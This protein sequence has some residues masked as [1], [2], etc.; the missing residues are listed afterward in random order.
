MRVLMPVL[1]LAT[2]ILIMVAAPSASIAD[3]PSPSY[4]Y[5]DL[6][7]DDLIFVLDTEDTS[8]EIWVPYFYDEASSDPR[9]IR[10]TGTMMIRN[11]IY[12]NRATTATLHFELQQS[13]LMHRVLVLSNNQGFGVPHTFPEETGMTTVWDGH[14]E[15]YWGGRNGNCDGRSGFVIHAD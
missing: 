11:S 6:P 12:S 9:D 15:V 4:P 2:V 14:S 8:G 5:Y 10:V 3:E 13:Y 1:L 7:W